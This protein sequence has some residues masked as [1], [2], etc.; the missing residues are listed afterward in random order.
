MRQ[1]RADRQSQFKL[2][3]QGLN[4][5]TSEMRHR[6]EGEAVEAAGDKV[7]L[8]LQQEELQERNEEI[9]RLRII[10]DGVQL[11]AE[12]AHLRNTIKHLRGEL[13]RYNRMITAIL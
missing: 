6:E 3:F 1:E 11:P 12:E 5:L 10:L 13:A 7:I 8:Q 4:V 9:M 2:L